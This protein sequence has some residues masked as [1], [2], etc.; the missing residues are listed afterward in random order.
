M[1]KLI[2]IK[3]NLN[4]ECY[5][6]IDFLNF[7]AHDRCFIFKSLM[8]KKPWSDNKILPDLCNVFFKHIADKNERRCHLW[9]MFMSFYY[10]YFIFLFGFVFSLTCVPELLVAI[11]GED[12]QQVAQDVH[13]DGEDKKTAQS[14]GNP[15]RAAQRGVTGLCRRVVQ[16]RLIYNH[17]TLC[18]TFPPD[19]SPNS[20]LHARSPSASPEKQSGRRWFQTTT[21]CWVHPFSSTL[22]IL[23]LSLP[24]PGSCLF[25]TLLSARLGLCCSRV[26]FTFCRVMKL[27][28]RNLLSMWPNKRGARATSLPGRNT[29]VAWWPRNGKAAARA[30]PWWCALLPL[31]PSARSFMAYPLKPIHYYFNEPF[32]LVLSMEASPQIANYIGMKRIICTENWTL[33]VFSLYFLFLYILYIFFANIFYIFSWWG[34]H[35]LKSLQQSEF[36]PRYFKYTTCSSNIYWNKYCLLP[37]TKF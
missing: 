24:L 34:F 8:K 18:G 30:V 31:D 17:C 19:L 13:H 36:W 29:T 28:F 10:F 27:H 21:S 9:L 12:N 16:V 6:T 26:P 25:R 4:R 35:R 33:I 1:I 23:L 37:M 15:G 11:H 3:I 20:T 7:R 5:V 14:C 2:T 22:L 32:M